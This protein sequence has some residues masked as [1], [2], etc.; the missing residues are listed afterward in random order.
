MVREAD[1][2]RPVGAAVEVAEAQEVAAEVAAAVVGEAVGEAVGADA[3][4]TAILRPWCLSRLRLCWSPP[5]LRL[6]WGVPAEGTEGF[7]QR[8]SECPEFSA[9]AR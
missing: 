2:D 8:R 5:E 6:L 4:R 9:F 1:R 7:G 3:L